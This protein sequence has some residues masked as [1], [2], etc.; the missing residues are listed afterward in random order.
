MSRP[1]RP[2]LESIHVLSWLVD[3]FIVIGAIALGLLGVAL[4]GSAL[5]TVML[6][7]VLISSLRS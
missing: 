7:C 4:L 1:P 3:F 6:L 2:V 5:L